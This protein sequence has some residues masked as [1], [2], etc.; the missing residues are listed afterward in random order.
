MDLGLGDKVAFITGASGG[1]GRALAQAF[2]A[3]G[4]R[5]VLAG[6]AKASELRDWLERQE[7]R[8]RGLAV[9]VDVRN[10]N[11]LE[12]AFEK[13]LETFGRVDCCIA[14]A[15]AWT[16]ESLRLHEADERRIRESIEVNLLGSMWTARAFMGALA[17][18]GARPDGHGASLVFIGSTAGRFGEAGHAEY[19]TAKAGL[20]GLM[21]S[22][23]NEIVTL[24]PFARVNVVE[25]GWTVT[26]MVRP[27]LDQPGV[28]AKVLATMP[29][30]QLGR[31]ADVAACATWL[32]SPLAARHVSG[33]TITI[34][35]GM[36]GR[37]L[38]SAR[39][40]DGAAVRARARG[41]S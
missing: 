14:N 20:I 17:R 36:E 19:A 32:C 41:E 13:A 35:G 38:W 39:D 25:P 30:R 24:D 3:E 27:A 15:G 23:K 7:W 2:A 6:Y 18:T 1:I 33:Q 8:E 22:L 11:A 21:R 4:S 9:H 31:A 37:Q 10:P 16:P 40:V 26:H 5:V 12:S 34:A 29:V 28:I